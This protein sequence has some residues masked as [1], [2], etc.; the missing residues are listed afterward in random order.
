MA[1]RLVVASHDTE[2]K[3]RFSSASYKPWDDRVH[4]PLAR[5]DSIRM[6]VLHDEALATIVEQDAGVW[7]HQPASVG[8]KD[9]IDE[10]RDISLLVDNRNINSVRVLDAFDNRVG[11]SRLIDIDPSDKIVGQF[12]GQKELDRN[13]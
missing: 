11:L 13:I 1:H 5:A 12:V 10:A 7:C 2:R 6:T 9:R 8:M 4:R 3:H